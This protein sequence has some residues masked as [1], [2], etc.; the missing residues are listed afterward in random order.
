MLSLRGWAPNITASAILSNRRMN[1][2][3]LL[4]ESLV[5][6]LEFLRGEHRDLDSAINELDRIQVEDELLLR[7]LKKRRLVLKDR[8]RTLEQL[9]EPDA[10]A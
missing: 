1:D 2:R 4:P 3:E 5:E 9:L 10:P 8:I 6:R 7:R